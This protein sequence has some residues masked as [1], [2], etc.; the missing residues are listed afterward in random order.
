MRVMERLLMRLKRLLSFG[1]SKRRQRCGGGVLEV[2]MLTPLC[3][4]SSPVRIAL[5][6]RIELWRCLGIPTKEIRVLT[7]IPDGCVAVEVLILAEGKEESR[8]I[9]LTQPKL[10]AT[11][12]PVELTIGGLVL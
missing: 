10:S 12:A 3:I 9:R 4:A 1:E 2:R 6:D 11:A 5:N 7:G 8:G